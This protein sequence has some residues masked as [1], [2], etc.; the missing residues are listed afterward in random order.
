LV[1]FAVIW[2]FLPCLVSCTEKYLAT[3]LLRNHSP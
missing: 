3:L 2:Y 1:H